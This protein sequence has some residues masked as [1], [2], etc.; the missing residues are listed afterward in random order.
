MG[1]RLLM[2]TA[3]LRGGNSPPVLRKFNVRLL[4]GRACQWNSRQADFLNITKR[5]FTSPVA[6]VRE[7]SLQALQRPA[8]ET[9]VRTGGRL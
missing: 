1:W 2:G 6:Q 9:L 3:D 8:L 5:L 7:A 4:Q